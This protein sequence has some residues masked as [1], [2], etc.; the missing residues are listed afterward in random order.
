M[1][2]A[3]RFNDPRSFEDTLRDAGLHP[4]QVETRE[5]R[6][7]LPLDDY[8]LHRMTSASGRFVRSMLGEDGWKG[9]VQKAADVYRDRFPARINDFRDVLLAVGT[10]ASGGLQR[11]DVQGSSR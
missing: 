6:I 4:V 5:Y 8:I 9:F 2:W 3:T 7:Q 1:P 11:Q 10:K